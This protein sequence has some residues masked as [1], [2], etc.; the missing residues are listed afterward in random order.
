MQTTNHHKSDQN[1][2]KKEYNIPQL[3][4]IKADE[5]D[6]RQRIIDYIS[7]EEEPQKRG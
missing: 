6:T 1:S 2:T 5:P 7:L 4:N 3:H